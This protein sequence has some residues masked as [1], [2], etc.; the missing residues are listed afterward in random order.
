MIYRLPSVSPG[1]MVE[2]YF[3]QTLCSDVYT[4]NIWQ[5][6]MKSGMMMVI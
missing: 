5:K 4:L 6:R 1:T 2:Q 3:Q